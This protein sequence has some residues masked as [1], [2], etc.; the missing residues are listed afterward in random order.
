MT[1]VPAGTSSSL[2]SMVIFVIFGGVLIS[3][4]PPAR[5]RAPPHVA[6]A[7]ANPA[8]AAPGSSVQLPG[9]DVQPPDDRDR[10]GEQPALD[11]LRIGLID[12]EAR[13]PYLHAARVLP[14]VAHDVVAQLAV[15]GF[16]VAV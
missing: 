3:K 9:D 1:V 12:V 15:G 10:V 7:E 16:R 11:H 5:I 4:H 6:R 13:R 8:L 2:P 14:P